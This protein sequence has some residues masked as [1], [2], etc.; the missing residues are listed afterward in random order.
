EILAPGVL[1]DQAHPDARAERQE[2]VAPQLVGQAGIAGKE[3]AE[4][5]TGMELGGGRPAR[6][7]WHGR[8]RVLSLFKQQNPTHRGGLKTRSPRLAK[9]FESGPSVVRLERDCEQLSHFSTKICKS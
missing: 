2:F 7:G 3:D 4:Q 9:S 6:P 5:G 1:H 8:L